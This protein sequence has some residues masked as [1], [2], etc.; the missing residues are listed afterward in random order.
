MAAD[1]RK[2]PPWGQV[3]KKRD[4][5]RKDRRRITKI[6]KFWRVKWKHMVL[7]RTVSLLSCGG[8]GLTQSDVQHSAHHLLAAWLP[9]LC[10]SFTTPFS[11]HFNILPQGCWNPGLEGTYP[12]SISRGNCQGN[13][14]PSYNAPDLPVGSENP[15]G[16]RPLEDRVL[17]TLLYTNRNCTIYCFSS[18]YEAISWKCDVTQKW[19]V[20][21]D[22][23][24]VLTDP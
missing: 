13:W 14:E 11:C 5:N 20:M 1:G 22:W 17:T 18:T 9:T 23:Y 8:V 21:S 12:V 19:Q 24:Q 15:L 7:I 4:G 16:L 2:R 6:S 10:F 3:R